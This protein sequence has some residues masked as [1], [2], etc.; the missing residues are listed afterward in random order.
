MTLLLLVTGRPVLDKQRT[1]NSLHMQVRRVEQ[2]IVHE[3][4]LLAVDSGYRTLF[5][6]RKS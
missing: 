2:S 5:P 3:D 1:G 6:D 4:D